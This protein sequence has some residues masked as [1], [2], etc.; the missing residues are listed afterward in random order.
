MTS[1]ARIETGVLVLTLLVLAAASGLS[2]VIECFLV[3]QRV[4]GHLWLPVVLAVAGN[5]LIGGVGGVGTRTWA[6]AAVPLIAW[7]AVTGILSSTGPGGDV[8]LPAKLPNDAAV[9]H[10]TAVFLVAGIVAGLAA[11]FVTGRYTGRVNQPRT[12]E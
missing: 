12:D 8:I 7:F 5:F 2:A 3:P 6:G 9:T 1:R 11:F 4:A 10:V